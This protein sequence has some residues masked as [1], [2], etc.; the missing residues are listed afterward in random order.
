MRITTGPGTDTIPARTRC[1]GGAL[2]TGC[3][4]EVTCSC[5]EHQIRTRAQE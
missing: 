4:Q 3:L 5:E 1:T 2:R